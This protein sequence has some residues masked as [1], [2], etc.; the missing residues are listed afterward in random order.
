M[1]VE[2][3]F[4]RSEYLLEVSVAYRG[5]DYLKRECLERDFPCFGGNK[6]ERLAN[7]TIKSEP[8]V[9][10]PEDLINEHLDYI[11]SRIGNKVKKNYPGNTF[12]IIPIVPDTILM[13]EEWI[14]ILHKLESTDISMF[15]GLFVYDTISYK[16]AFI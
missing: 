3:Q 12:L 6:I 11:K 15:C 9:R 5:K 10:T 1:L 8:T 7:R 14:G 16:M 4:L 13:R 2:K